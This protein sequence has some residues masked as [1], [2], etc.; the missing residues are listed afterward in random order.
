MAAAGPAAGGEGVSVAT[1]GPAAGGE[2]VSVIVTEMHPARSPEAAVT[3][4]RGR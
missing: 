3:R 2:G 4:G 1:A